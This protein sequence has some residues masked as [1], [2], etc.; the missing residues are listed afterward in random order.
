MKFK[1]VLEFSYLFLKDEN[2][3]TFTTDFIIT[4]KSLIL[5]ILNLKYLGGGHAIGKCHKDRSGYDGP[6][7]NAPI[8][9]TNLYFKELLDKNWKER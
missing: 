4:L 3:F 2:I 1:I 5:C 6:W 9:F 8:S 7:T